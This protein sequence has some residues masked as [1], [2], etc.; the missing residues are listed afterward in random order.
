MS[1]DE[2]LLTM[3]K[4]ENEDLRNES[5]SSLD[6]DKNREENPQSL[7]EAVML[8]KAKKAQAEKKK[9]GKEEPVSVGG[10]GMATAGLL[11]SAWM[12]VVPSFGL[13]LLWVDIHLVLGTIFG[14]KYFC[15]LGD[16]WTS[17]RAG[18][19]NAA[20]GN[21]KMI[22]IAEPMGLMIGNVILFL[23][24]LSVVALITMI[25]GFIESPLKAIGEMLRH[26]FVENWNKI[27]GN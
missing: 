21:N 2:R 20:K 17:G 13:S 7:R 27:L 14:K 16:E 8:E 11:R 25:A 26:I 1:V 24:I 12:S 6:V 19:V 18:A 3:N 4:G 5:N 22:N 10:V 15:R 23:A 9:K